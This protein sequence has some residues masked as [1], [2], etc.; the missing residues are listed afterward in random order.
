MC[1]IN[2]KN[3][4]LLLEYR[5]VLNELETLTNYEKQIIENR[6]FII[7]RELEASCNKINY[8]FHVFRFLITSGS[9][10]I[11]AFISIQNIKD[12]QSI[13][14]N[15]TLVIYW[16]TWFLSVIVSL[17]N[18]Y[19][20][21]YKI[22]KQYY[23]YHSAYERIRSEGWQ[24][25]QLSGKYSYI[26]NT[27][28]DKIKNSHKEQLNYFCMEIE[29]LKMI[30]V[31]EEYIRGSDD[32]T[33]ANV[34]PGSTTESGKITAPNSSNIF[35]KEIEQL[36]YNH[37]KKVAKKRKGSKELGNKRTSRTK[38]LDLSPTPSIQNITIP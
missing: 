34:K 20:T 29:R 27:N 3:G 35:A 17:C 7:I 13:I 31:A 2:N 12:E 32:N 33:S 26:H 18:A 30:L 38:Q 16:M 10:L 4:S 36:Q 6:F 21:L 15:H 22:D 24:F 1:F 8:Y 11:P 23:L 9:L 28:H 25:F 37:Q 5:S 14:P 19:Y